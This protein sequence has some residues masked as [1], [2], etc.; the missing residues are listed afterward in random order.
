MHL[1][2]GCWRSAIQTN[3]M[4]S[5]NAA[6]IIA[7]L[8]ELPAGGVY[9]F[10]FFST[11]TENVFP[12]WPGDTVVVFA[13]FLLA[14]GVIAWGG[15]VAT[16]FAGN[17]FSAWVMYFLGEHLLNLARSVHDRIKNPGLV[18]SWLRELTAEEN[19][20]R[21]HNLFERWG[22]YFVL[23]SRFSAGIRFFVSIIAGISKMNLLVFTLSFAGG[24]CIWNAIL[25]GG[26]YALGENYERILDWLR[27]YNVVVLSLLALLAAVYLIFR[28]RRA[29]DAPPPGA[30]G[31]A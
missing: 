17:M 15:V 18:R 13:G 23:F 16:T 26:G 5:I 4:E 21:T 22:V 12:P 2:S 1:R 30:H 14:H 9:V 3:R 28:A 8:S 29:K 20:Q 10:L 7:F 6:S 19:L 11:F 25:L 27:V 31:G 24:V